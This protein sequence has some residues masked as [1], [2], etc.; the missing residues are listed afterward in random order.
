MR[1]KI[2]YD[3]QGQARSDEINRALTSSSPELRLLGSWQWRRHVRAGG[4]NYL[5]I[6]SDIL[7]LVNI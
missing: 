4:G 3:L 6:M 5:E 1:Q 2:M 7:I